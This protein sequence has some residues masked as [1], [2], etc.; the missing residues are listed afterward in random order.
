MS[1]SGHLAAV[2]I[3]NHFQRF[4]TMMGHAVELG[5]VVKNPCQGVIITKPELTE[6]VVWDE[7]QVKHFNSFL[8]TCLLR[9][10][11]LFMLLLKTGAR[12]GE[13]LALRWTDI[14][15]VAG[16]ISITRTATAKGYNP[17][18]S[19]Y[20]TRKVPLD[21]GTI[22]MLSKHRTQQGKEKLLHGE[23]YNPENLVFCKR[24]GVRLPYREA[25][26]AYVC[27]VSGSGLPYLPMHR[28][29]HLHATMLLKDGNHSIK[30]VAER[31]G[32]SPATIEKTYAHVLTGMREAIVQTIEQMYEERP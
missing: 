14:D 26:E 3:Y 5:Y 10:T 28:L 31:L 22:K 13:I 27:L 19:K 24:R 17:P 30:A 7:Q 2:T 32:D 20:G 25:R 1:T 12:I 23:G 15:F 16:T 18:K 4:H 29:R 6:K 8:K 21:Q 9:Y 11:A